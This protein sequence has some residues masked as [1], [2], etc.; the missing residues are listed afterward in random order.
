[1]TS[2]QVQKEAQVLPPTTHPLPIP[3]LIKITPP[4]QSQFSHLLLHYNETAA[5]EGCPSLGAAD[6]SFHLLTASVLM[7]H[8]EVLSRWFHLRK[9]ET[10]NA[11][12]RRR[13]NWT[14][15]TKQTFE[16]LCFLGIMTC[17]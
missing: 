10:K 11:C 9:E 14:Q 8:G 1:M 15:G 6:G 16:H 17:K 12:S 3:Y 13:I 2:G 4:P 7:R 5:A